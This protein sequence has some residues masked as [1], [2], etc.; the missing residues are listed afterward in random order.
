[1]SELSSVT[2]TVDGTENGLSG[3]ANLRETTSNK[4][5]HSTIARVRNC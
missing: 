5:N 3:T 4:P 1:M 2:P